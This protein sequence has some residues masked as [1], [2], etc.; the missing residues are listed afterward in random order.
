MT[1]RAFEKLLQVKKVA[2]KRM[3]EMAKKERMEVEKRWDVESAYYSS[4]LE[5]SRVTKK[6]FEKIAKEID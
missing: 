6:E 3:R 4:A 2:D 5:G 1:K